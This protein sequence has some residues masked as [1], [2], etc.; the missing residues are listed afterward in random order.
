MQKIL[1]LFTLIATLMFSSKSFAEWEQFATSNRGHTHHYLESDT[2]K[3]H[4]GYVYYWRMVDNWVPDERGDISHQVYSEG[5]C[6][7]SRYKTLTYIHYKIRMGGGPS[8]QQESINKDWKYPPP[9]RVAFM[10]LFHGIDLLPFLAWLCSNNDHDTKVNKSCIM[11]LVHG[12]RLCLE[13]VVLGFESLPCE[14]RLA[15][16]GIM[17]L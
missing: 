10:A 11:A 14:N 16:Q 5:D 17:Y 1:I 12:H 15:R 6:K 9:D 8:N 13:A 3:E 7:L 4:S 2:V